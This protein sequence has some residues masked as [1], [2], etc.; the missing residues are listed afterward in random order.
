MD[1]LVE[2]LLAEGKLDVAAVAA[3]AEAQTAELNTGLAEG[4]LVHGGAF[5]GGVGTDPGTGGQ[6]QG[7]GGG[8]G[9]F[10]ELAAAEVVGLHIL[11]CWLRVQRTRAR[12]YGCREVPLF[13]R[14]FW[15]RLEGADGPRM[16]RRLT[17]GHSVRMMAA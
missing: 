12:Y 8:G 1:E 3:G 7:P 13:Q 11:L 2:G 14:T 16:G 17:G 15:P 9:A 10:E 5:G 6:Q 4:D